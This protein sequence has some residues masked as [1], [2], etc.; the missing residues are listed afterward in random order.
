MRIKNQLDMYD[1]KIYPRKIWVAI[2]TD[3]LKEYFTFYNTKED[4]QV[5]DIT[6]DLEQSDTFGMGTFSVSRKSDG[7]YGVLI[8]IPSLDSYE[9]T[10]ITHEAVHA[11][12]Y[13]YQEIGA[14]SGTFEDGNEP[15]AYL[16]GWIAGCISKSLI[17]AKKDDI[18]RK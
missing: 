7:L 14:C 16:V 6:K 18:R 11:A 1:P 9:N 12:D 3:G 13:I 5:I 4:K 2:G 10:D 17:K 8:V 15:Y